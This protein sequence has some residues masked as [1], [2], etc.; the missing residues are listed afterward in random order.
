MSNDALKEIP[1]SRISELKEMAKTNP[2]AIG[3]GY[4]I[5]WD[6]VEEG[7]FSINTGVNFN[8]I[9]KCFKCE[10]EISEYADGD[11]NGIDPCL[12]KLEGVVSA[13]CGH[14]FISEAY[15]VLE[16]G[17]ELRGMEAIKMQKELKLK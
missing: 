10:C 17:T 9:T 14:G 11:S 15:V 3:K 13:C 1:Q 6:S 4:P 5:V 12:G 2:T 8:D 7:W 16:D